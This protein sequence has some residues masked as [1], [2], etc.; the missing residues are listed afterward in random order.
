MSNSVSNP[1]LEGQGVPVALAD[2]EGELVR[3]W[4]PA[5]IQAGGD[6]ADAPAVTRVVLANLIVECLD[7]PARVA[8]VLET[9]MARYPCRAIVLCSSDATG[10][11][12]EA[13][14]SALCHLPA[15]GLPQVCSERIVLRAGPSAHGLFPG[16]VRPLLE[17]DVPLILWWTSDPTTRPG[18]YRELAAE[19]SRVILDLPDPI[20]PAALALGLDRAVHHFSRDSTWFAITGWREL[21]AQLFDPACLAG[22]LD[23]IAQVAIEVVTPTVAGLPRSGVWLAAWL[24][25]Q[26][27]WKPTGPATHSSEGSETRLHASF[28]SP[29]GPVEVVLVARTT[30]EALSKPSIASVTLTCRDPRGESTLRLARPSPLSP[31]V[32]IDVT[33]PEACRLPRVVDSPDPKP[34][35]R[36]AAALASARLDPPFD[37]ALAVATRLLGVETT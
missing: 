28:E 30:T 32:R 12:I 6:Q 29:S 26:L 7:D 18:L 19:C 5:A 10:R 37:R 31:A 27:G 1:F 21:I 24:A 35:E 16:A 17:P 15:P 14:A 11:G 13:E 20:A 22:S 8:S 34:E 4:G 9:V 3:L 33:S 36:I 25:G 23:R 2:V